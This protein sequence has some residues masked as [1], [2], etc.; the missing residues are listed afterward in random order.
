MF[1]KGF[2]ILSFVPIT[3]RIDYSH[4]F[5]PERFSG[6]KNTIGVEDFLATLE[7]S[8]GLLED[9]TDLLKR[10]RAKVLILQGHLDGKAKQFWLTLRTN[11]KTTFELASE[12]LRQR[13][14]KRNNSLEGW[15]ETVRPISEMSVLTQG[16]LTS[17]QYVEKAI[18][19]FALLGD[20]YSLV[21]ATKFIDGIANDALRTIID[22]QFDKAYSS[23]EVI[24]VYEKCTKSLRRQEIAR[25]QL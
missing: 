8:F 3:T 16:T 19:L 10:E 21:L 6:E 12:A 15:A 1:A 14:P 22:A 13:F 9:I 5:K 25:Q 7:I 20:E 17:Q 24:K 4:V 23:V 18:D 11:K 2:R